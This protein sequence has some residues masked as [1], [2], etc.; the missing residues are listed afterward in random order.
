MA[1]KHSKIIYKTE[2]ITNLS[3]GFF[4]SIYPSCCLRS[5]QCYLFTLGFLCA[6]IKKKKRK[7]SPKK[8]HKESDAKSYMPNGLHIRIWQNICALSS[9]LRKPFLIYDFAHDPFWISNESMGKIFFSLLAVCVESLTAFFF[10]CVLCIA[11]SSDYAV[12][13]L[14]HLH[15]LAV[16]CATRLVGA[17]LNYHLETTTK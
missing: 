16:T 3:R 4:V 13:N 9:Y 12:Q 7:F 15:M 2:K 17:A 11:A 6:L 5:R 14:T 1:S 10:N 8:M